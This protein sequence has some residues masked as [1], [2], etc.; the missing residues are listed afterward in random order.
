MIDNNYVSKQEQDDR[1]ILKTFNDDL[2]Y[3]QELTFT[4]DKSRTDAYAIDRKGRK[5]H[6]EIKQRKGNYKDFEKFKEKYDSCYLSTDKIPWFQKINTSGHT[7]QEQQ[8]FVTIFD[9]GDTILLFNLLK[10][11]KV[12]FQ[13]NTRVWNPMYK[14]WKYETNIGFKIENALIYKKI[15]GHYKLQN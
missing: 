8:L 4:P 7:L 10:Q 2:N 11:Q 5:V 3:F 9:D 1:E 14:C 15:N 13:P 6:I 12:D